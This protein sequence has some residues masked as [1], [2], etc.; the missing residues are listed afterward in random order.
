[1]RDVAV[2]SAI[3]RNDLFTEVATRRG[4]TFDAAQKDFWVCLALD[5]LFSNQAGQPAFY[6]RGGTSLSKCFGLI[7]RFSEDIDI[8][9][10][11]HDLGF[12]GDTD[13]RVGPSR[14]QETKRREAIK[15][16]AEQYVVGELHPL[17]ER[18]LKE[19][20]GE[21]TEHWSLEYQEAG[22][23]V[24]TFPFDRSLTVDSYVSPRVLL[25]IG[26]LGDLTP[27][28][29]V[30]VSSYAAEEFPNAF[31]HPT[32]QVRA[33]EAVRTLC[34]KLLVIH[35]LCVSDAPFPSE[36]SRH[37]YDVVALSSS[38]A[39]EHLLR[40]PGLLT[41]A[42]T[43]ER[44]AYPRGG[45]RYYEELRPGDLQFVPR[46]ETLASLKSDYRTM[47][48]EMIWGESPSF[49]TMM[50]T[51]EVLQAELQQTMAA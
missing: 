47:S 6:F 22:K 15:T 40:E 26:A 14:N 50:S 31:D 4:L 51:L 5:V 25:A 1:M 43:H 39:W 32:V 13:L 3:D 35:R 34:D 42:I 11:R 21:P 8:T 27:S 30:S 36:Q 49:E 29:A 9:L 23:L 20:L 24:F 10:S 46:Q 2:W 17:L 48:T 19:V 38:T 33:I 41:Q 45:S 37:F 18:G 44:L 7:K 12:K 16:K 28:V